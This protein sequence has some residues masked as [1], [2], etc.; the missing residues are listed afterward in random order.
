[1]LLLQT[2]GRDSLKR[3]GYLIIAVIIVTAWVI[4]CG[5]TTSG[6]AAA[7][8]AEPGTGDAGFRVITEEFPPLSY[9]RPDGKATGLATDVVIGILRRLNQNANIEILPWNEGYGLAGAGPRVALFSTGR[10]DEREQLFKWVGPITSVDYVFYAR[11]GSSLQI[12]SIEAAKKLGSVGVVKEDARH[13]FLQENRFNNIAT[14]E[15][16]AECLH[17]L[18][19]GSTDLWF[20]TSVNSADVAKNE[21]IDRAAFRPV[22][23]VRTVEM[24]IAFSNDT[25]DS[26]IK[27]WQDALDMMKCDGTFEEIRKKYGFTPVPVSAVPASAD[28]LADQ[29][30]NTM[31]AQTDGQLKAILRPFE[32]LAITPDVQSG[33]WQAV[34]PLLAM[35]EGYEPDARTWYAL[36][37]GSYYTIVDDLTSANLKSR[38]YFP[39]V[40]AGN[41]SVGT[42]VVSYS[43]GKNTAIVAVP[44][45][46]Q[47]SVTG[48]LGA[49]V[50]LD[51]LTDTLRNEIPEPFVFFA[52]DADGKFALHSA[53]GQISRDITV[54]GA[55]TSF[56]KAIASIRRSDS[57]TVE[58]D[59]GGVH[60]LARFRIS[61]LTGWRFVVAW[62]ETYTG[63]ERVKDG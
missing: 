54:I 24:Y 47:G 52:I 46:K 33:R 55:D 6:P 61:P 4:T 63:T 50:Y 20:G 43:T 39:A 29:A 40:L 60:Y 8:T 11:N 57:G 30:L 7:G 13:Q 25:P 26:V 3:A 44:V 53:R 49:S 10:T 38:S 59:D 28:A 5:C 15:H 31:V 37:D 18:M 12:S 2:I 48:V 36:P 34:R 14:C 56:G 42:V 16:D 9:A 32:V 35:L 45:I 21:G 58:F 27:N 51:A 23:T 1:L 62:P 19:A 17:S 22:Y 41:E